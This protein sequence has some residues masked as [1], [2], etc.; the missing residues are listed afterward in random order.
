[1]K[2]YFLSFLALLSSLSFFLFS[3]EEVCRAVF[4]IGSNRTKMKVAIVDPKEQKVM[5]ILA[6]EKVLLPLRDDLL[7]SPT[8][9]FSPE[10]IEQ[11]TKVLKQFKDKAEQLG[12]T[13]YA[14]IATAS[15]R[16][17]TNAD[18]FMARVQEETAIPIQIISQEEE[19][20]LG[21]RGVA[22]QMPDAQHLVVWDVGGGSMQLSTLQNADQLII[23]HGKLGQ[24]VFKAQVMKEVQ[25]R[26]AALVRSPNPMI[27]SEVAKAIEL[28]RKDAKNVSPE[29]GQKLKDPA[30]EVVG[31]GLFSYLGVERNP[32]RIYSV[33]DL[34]RAV[35]KKT[36]FNDEEL[37][38]MPFEEGPTG[39]TNLILILGYMEELGISE[40]QEMDV[41]MTDAVLISPQFF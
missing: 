36:G 17:A 29:L 2:K 6:D 12:A 4:D 3:Q 24:K 38:M 26:D 10:V 32:E 33:E 41:N 35:E 28:A 16:A 22:M 37:R 15:L 18:Q 5:R 21:F 27:G 20:T 30:T 31:I 13:E 19:G 39:L 25:K 9:T 14:C 11:G 7:R 1:M 40:V 34:R 23:Y 8:A